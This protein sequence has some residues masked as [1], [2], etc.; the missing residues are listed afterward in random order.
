MKKELQK[1][2][3]I[4]E[5]LK[6]KNSHM[7]DC[8]LAELNDIMDEASNLDSTFEDLENEI[9]E[10]KE[11]VRDREDDLK[12]ANKKIKALENEV[13][14]L[15]EVDTV[16]EI[17]PGNTVYDEQKR[18]ICGFLFRNLELSQLEDLKQNAI[19]S[20]TIKDQLS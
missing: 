13:E 1:I 5:K 2:Y 9:E 11:G 3:D 15:E 16:Q 6:D 4:A 10:L 19:S 7:S 17:L 20:F 12:E 14:E 18:E 8:D